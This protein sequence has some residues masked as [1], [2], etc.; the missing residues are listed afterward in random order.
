MMVSNTQWSVISDQALHFRS[1]C[2]EFVVYNSLSG[3]TH[4]LGATAAHV[5]LRLQQSPSDVAM[6]ATS[7]APLL[8]TEMNDEWLFQIGQI[9][10]D[11]DKL[12]LIEQ[13]RP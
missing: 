1:W 2:D 8:Q 13:S 12:S 9:L 11:L 5:L 4:L 6:L 10:A 7:I 3:D